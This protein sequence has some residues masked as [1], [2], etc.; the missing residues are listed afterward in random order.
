MH[1]G[2]Y[3]ILPMSISHYYPRIRIIKSIVPC[4][5]VN[6]SSHPSI[7]QARGTVRLK[8]AVPSKLCP[9]QDLVRPGT[10]PINMSRGIRADGDVPV[11]SALISWNRVVSCFHSPTLDSIHRTL[12]TWLDFTCSNEFQ[13]MRNRWNRMSQPPP[14]QCI[15]QCNLWPSRYLT[16]P[17]QPASQPVYH[18]LPDVPCI[19]QIHLRFSW[20]V[21]SLLQLLVFYLP[22]CQNGR[23]GESWE[24]ATDKLYTL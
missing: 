14:G 17:S 21:P 13:C 22:R 10:H 1:R 24:R 2:W 4:Q 23:H 8:A 18:T 5:P 15:R 12:T 7:Y 9:W 20:R 16:L 6:L 11:L 19:A 3:Y